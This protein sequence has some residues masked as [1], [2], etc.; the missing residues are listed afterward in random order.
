MK[1]DSLTDEMFAVQGNWLVGS[2]RAYFGSLA[3]YW[4]MGVE[5]TGWGN[6]AATRGDAITAGVWVNVVIVFTGTAAKMY[7]NGIYKYEIAYS[8]YTFNQNL[9]IGGETSAS[10]D[11]DGKIGAVAVFDKALT[12][13]QIKENFNQQRNRFGI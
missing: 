11:W 5:A 8:S 13:Q 10:Y 9:E 4:N 7:N 3:S 12:A 2:Q 6:T 1:Q